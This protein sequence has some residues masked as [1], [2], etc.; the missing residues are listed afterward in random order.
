MRFDH[1]N[2]KFSLYNDQIEDLKLNQHLTT[3]EVASQ[4][5]DKNLDLTFQDI[6]SLSRYI[7][8]HIK[9]VIS[10]KEIVAEN[11][12]LAKQKQSYQDKNRIERKAF[13]E[14]ARIENALVEYNKELIKLIKSEGLK[15]ETRLHEPDNEDCILLLQLSDLH[16]N[17][18][19][20][21]PT[22]KFDFLV[23]SKR[24]QK[25]ANQ[26]IKMGQFQNS[27]TLVIAFLGDLLN[28]DRRLDEL[29]SM[30]T[31][32]AKATQLSI[33]LLKMFLLHLNEHFNIYCAGVTGNESRAKQELGWS[34]ILACDSYD[35]TIY[36]N[37]KMQ[38]EDKEGFTFE[39]ME[40]NEK[41]INV[42]NKN[43]LL[44]HGH[45]VKRNTQQSVQQIIGKYATKGITIDYVI[46]GHIHSSDI[47]DY[48]SR[49]ASLTGSNAYSEEAL[50]FVSKAAQN[51]HIVCSDDT[52]H[53][54]KIDLQNYEGYSGYP[55]EYQ[56]DA[57]N[58][59]SVK[60]T[61]PHTR[62]MEIVI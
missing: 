30:A 32:R 31:N 24:L 39:M 6:D 51:L 36:D 38:F 61:K 25:L 12:K 60:K 48:Y 42:N 37:L 20:D 40:A 44:I 14:H 10:D 5:I 55:I 46:F 2:G 21:L 45:Q 53:S 22:N 1:E 52:I 62:I 35:F 27:K 23:A 59:K 54:I 49:N 18:L 50:N 7:N 8:E 3:R 56:V 29:L 34:E 33:R 43:F 17:E 19:V 58:A 4:L 9:Y 11:V 26:V 41:I 47:S 16:L 57:Y 28:S 15:T 13:R